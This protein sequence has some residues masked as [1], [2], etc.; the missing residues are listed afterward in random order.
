M[1]VPS[2]VFDVAK[3]RPQLDITAPKTKRPSTHFAASDLALYFCMATYRENPEATGISKQ[4]NAIHRTFH[5]VA[6]G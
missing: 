2:V 1:M 6:R 5:R 4:N 3:S